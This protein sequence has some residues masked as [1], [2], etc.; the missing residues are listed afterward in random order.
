MAGPSANL[1]R[2]I[3]H[4]LY[5]AAGQA[6]SGEIGR[7]QVVANYDP[8]R[9]HG[10]H[11]LTDAVLAAGHRHQPAIIPGG[12]QRSEDAQELMEDHQA[13]PACRRLRRIQKNHGQTKPGPGAPSPEND[14]EARRLS[15][16]KAHQ[17]EVGTKRGREQLQQWRRREQ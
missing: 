1:H 7:A 6:E 2:E 11:R 13:D 17:Q 4:L 10:P 14:A 9:I 16:S 12:M 5:G 8:H 15:N 3:L